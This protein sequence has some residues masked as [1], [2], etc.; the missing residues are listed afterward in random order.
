MVFVP[1]L[2]SS[3]K[4]SPTMKRVGS[5]LEADP[6]R[7]K[8]DDLDPNSFE[9]VVLSYQKKAL[10]LQ[11][12]EYKRRSEML[13][14]D[15]DK[16]RHELSQFKSHTSELLGC[17]M[18]IEKG[19]GIET[20]P[21]P[22]LILDRPDADRILNQRVDAILRALEQGDAPY[23]LKL[24]QQIARLQSQ[25]ALKNTEAEQLQAQ[26][27]D[28][29]EQLHATEKK[30]DRI[31]LMQKPVEQEPEPSVQE[32]Q[33]VLPI[34]N[35]NNEQQLQEAYQLA[36]HRLQ[37]LKSLNQNRLS[38]LEEIN[39]LKIELQRERSHA[40]ALVGLEKQIRAHVQDKESL[41]TKSMT[42]LQQN[43]QLQLE[44]RTFTEQVRTDE[45]KQRKIV[46]QELKKQ[47]TESSR[48]RQERD[49]LQKQYDLLVSKA[50][51]EEQ[52]KKTAIQQL[53][54]KHS[55]IQMLETE[56]KRLKQS[57]A[58]AMSESALMEFFEQDPEANPYADLK[59]KLSLAETEIQ[60]LKP[61]AKETP[62]ITASMKP[63]QDKILFLEQELEKRKNLDADQLREKT[64]LLEKTHGAL[65]AE[66][67]AISKAYESLMEQNQKT[68]SELS[69]LEE[70]VQKATQ[71]K[72]KLEQKCSSLAKQSTAQNNTV[73]AFR[74]QSDKQL[75]Q[76]R[77]SEELVR[78]LTEQLQYLEKQIAAK[79][80]V[81]EEEK[82]KN[83]KSENRITELTTLLDQYNAR[84]EQ[85]NAF[86][87][88]KT[89]EAEQ[90]A[91]KARRAGEQ[92]MQL[93]SK[94]ESLSKPVSANEIAM[95]RQLEEYRL[96]LKCQSCNIN[97]KSHVL[98][99][100]MHTFCFDCIDKMVQSRQR[101]CPSCALAFGKEDV[102]QVY[103]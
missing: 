8:E 36:H 29:S 19:L 32:K 89:E 13:L 58:V 22:E 74:K 60:R 45:E 103:L 43:Q 75:E 7:I 27:H 53:E 11:Y 48:L 34:Q 76:I 67:E 31:R 95:Q 5:D 85:M 80:T 91:E 92:V 71:E 30:F 65:I 83:M 54:T 100:C 35:Q 79:D 18:T 15:I 39:T 17:I 40:S 99:K 44:R 93:Q 61:L 33:E 3:K 55:R 98:L 102:R 73:I 72:I 56:L 96:L 57:I 88:K 25:L 37:E 63:L 24:N 94:V 68:T 26:I 97:F 101:K 62:D 41:K 28:M 87:A 21:L 49:N 82:M 59:H 23:D 38:L 77:K 2:R 70:Q 9:A 66:V 50:S 6:K 81:A 47:Q 78:N 51:A 69:Q 10:Y 14:D 4:S 42:L 16:Y 46:E 20:D 12:A 90:E 64:N 52:S 84:M 1:F 86:L